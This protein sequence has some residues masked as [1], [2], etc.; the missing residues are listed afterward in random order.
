MKS[1]FKVAAVL[2]LA[3]L[4]LATL[5]ACSTDAAATEKQS[6]STPTSST[7][8]QSSSESTPA[9]SSSDP[10]APAVPDA[11]LN[12]EARALLPADVLSSGTI[13]AVTNAGFPPYEMYAADNK[14]II[15]RDI[16]FADALGQVLGITIEFEN[17]SFDAIIPGIDSQRYQLAISGLTVTPERLKAAD[18]VTYSESGS[19]LAVAPGNPLQ[20][21]V[22]DPSTLCGHT[23]GVTKGSSDALVNLP[24]L[25]EECTSAG[26]PAIESKEFP[27]EGSRLALSSGRVDA[28]LDDALSLAYSAAESEGQYELAE[29]PDVAAAPSGI[30]LTKGSPLTAAITAAVTDLVTEQKNVYEAINVRWGIPAD[31][32]LSA[33]QVSNN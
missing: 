6:S 29:G 20:L 8:T 10:A 2:T 27:D 25:N 23:I 12:E 19:N 4:T 14:T 5:A 15:G 32:I 18:F 21:K 26:K 22:S 30:A 28:I 13:T 9:Q 31:H 7:S 24:A 17:V 3:G 16:D 11:H 33:D 1:T